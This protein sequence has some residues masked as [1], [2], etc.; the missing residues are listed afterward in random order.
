MRLGKQAGF[1]LIEVTLAIVIG[2]IMIGGAV[3]LYQQGKT[4]A[5]NSRAKQKVESLRAMAEEMGQRNFGVY[6]TVD[7]LRTQWARR[8]ADDY[9]QSPWGGQINGF[10]DNT[11]RGISSE[12]ATDPNTGD[13][14]AIAG[15]YGNP[16]P[17][18]GGRP[19][20]LGQTGMLYYYRLPNRFRLTLYDRTSD[21]YVRTPDYAV[22]MA[23][24]DGNLFV[25]PTGAQPEQSDSEAENATGQVGN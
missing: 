23:N 18:G 17:N 2:V 10:D 21:R 1:T 16:L 19:A 9:N 3:V 25:F 6:P 11:N 14:T 7:Q 15:A 20:T 13:I 5:G 4:S 8:R 12:G 22:G 24:L